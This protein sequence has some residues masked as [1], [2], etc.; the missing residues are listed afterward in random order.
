[1]A[2]DNKPIQYMRYAIGEIA[3]VVIGILIALQVNNWNENRKTKK[4][5]FE[6]YN[7][8]KDD[9]AFSL[10]DLERGVADHYEWL[11]QTIKLRDHLMN[12][13]PLSD[14]L[15]R[16]LRN[17]DRDDQFF[18]RT[19]GYESLKSVGLKTLSNDTLRQQITNLFQLGFERIVG[20]GR[21]K[22]PIRNFTYL[23]PFIDTYMVLSEED[24][25]YSKFN[26]IDSTMMF[27]TKI[28][29]YEMLLGDE[30]L[31]L[32]LQDAI[33]LRKFKIWNYDRV[34]RWAQ[35]INNEID[36]ELDRNQN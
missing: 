11:D 4:T 1:M 28:K 5:E 16:H 13:L 19:S 7:E 21:D 6:I 35:K 20:L 18:P 31:L 2:D 34:I 36:E 22:A 27:V 33:S 8:I 32:K 10:N 30:K 14:D 25:Y 3:L 12:Q 23:S 15:A 9:L 24:I 17:I 26:E 29:N